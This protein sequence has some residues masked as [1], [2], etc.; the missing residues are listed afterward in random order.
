VSA[1]ASPPP[2]MEGGY[3]RRAVGWIAGVAAASFT[4]S[5]L[6]IFFGRDLSRPP[7]AV[8][9][10]FSRSV[11]GHRA[12]AELL[13]ALGLG[14][15]S[16]E[17]RAAFGTG[18]THP[19]IVAEPDP[20]RLRDDPTKRLA[21][22][23]GEVRR[24][25][26]PLVLVLPK[27]QGREL[28]KRPGWIGAL[29]LLPVAEV[30]R[31]LAA[32][33]APARQAPP[34]VRRLAGAGLG[35]SASWSTGSFFEVELAP[36]QLLAEDPRLEPVVHCRGGVLIGRFLPSGEVPDFYVVADPDLLNNQGL[37]RADHAAL[38]LGLLRQMA[39]T[40]VV[41]DETVHGFERASGLFAELFRFPLLPVL[42]QMLLAVGAVLW[43][44]AVRLGKPLPAAAG[45]PAGKE[46]LIDNTARLLA[47]GAR[48]DGAQ[49][50]GGLARYY[51]QSLRDVAAQLFLS[52]EGG[53]RELRERVQRSADAR[54]LGVDL[55]ALER[56]LGDVAGMGREEALALARAV[57]RFRLEMTDAK[58]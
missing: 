17:T 32:L 29:R 31:P 12:L 2:E 13:A 51:R 42:L 5:L 22:L 25:E 10:T 3:S 33:L 19:L 52:A 1:A 24:N 49:A 26:A 39:A 41:F 56:R 54:G 48:H 4:I 18:P 11:L 55:A 44:G 16:R 15:A 45:L 21:A 57:H 37:G 40:G 6:L 50:A 34:A 14:V 8:P 27:W 53:A 23:A 46:V 36:A 38:A 20:E 9:S 35:C 7:V 47:A 43:A 28:P 30:R 58:R